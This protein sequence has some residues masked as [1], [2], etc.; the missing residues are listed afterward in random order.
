MQTPTKLMNSQWSQSTL[1]TH[2][3]EGVNGIGKK[4]RKKKKKIGNRRKSFKIFN[5]IN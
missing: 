2:E 1:H 3:R 5:Y 4:K